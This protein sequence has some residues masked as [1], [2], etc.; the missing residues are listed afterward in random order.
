M[1][2]ISNVII[3]LNLNNLL[4]LGLSPDPSSV[5]VVTGSEAEILKTK[6]YMHL[7]PR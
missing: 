1:V 2:D 5:S 3:N 4:G 7:I 6:I